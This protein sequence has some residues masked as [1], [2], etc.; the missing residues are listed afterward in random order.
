MRT[1][2][3]LC[4]DATQI[5]YLEWLGREHAETVQKFMEFRTE[6][7]SGLAMISTGKE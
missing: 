7:L 4:I 3:D 2:L 1:W 6:W 5:N